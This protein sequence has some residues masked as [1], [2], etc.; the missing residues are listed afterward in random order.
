VAAALWKQSHPARVIFC[1]FSADAA[2]A[3]HDALSALAR[4]PSWRPA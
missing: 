2:G 1:A 4:D 3:L